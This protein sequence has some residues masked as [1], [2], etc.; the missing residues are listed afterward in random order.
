MRL[1]I[2]SS[3][4]Q[5]QF[6]SWLARVTSVQSVLLLVACIRLSSAIVDMKC[7]NVLAVFIHSVRKL[8][9]RAV[10]EQVASCK[11]AHGTHF[12]SKE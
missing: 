3:A 12:S 9:Y 4:L 2:T 1:A 5:M 11:K 8:Q 7:R 6:A 10:V